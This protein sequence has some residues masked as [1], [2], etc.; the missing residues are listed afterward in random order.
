M[1]SLQRRRE[2]YLIIYTWK[3]LEGLVPNLSSNPIQERSSDRRGRSCV[4]KPINRHTSVKI[5]SLRSNSFAVMGPRLFNIMPK[6]IRDT[7]GVTVDVF[8]HRLDKYLS[9]IPDEP[10]VR[11][12][13]AMRQAETNSIL[14][15]SRLAEAYCDPAVG[16][17]A[18]RHACGGLPRTPRD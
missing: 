15:M 5:Q 16:E 13:T 7:S 1:Y 11:G 10:Q 17:R 12:Y 8:K 14:D 4:E 2:R 18:V 6:F 3:V 9:S